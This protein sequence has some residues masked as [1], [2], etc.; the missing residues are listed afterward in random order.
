VS[1]NGTAVV[2]IPALAAGLY[3]VRADVIGWKE[4]RRGRLVPDDTFR[5]FA[6][7]VWLS[8]H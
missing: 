5:A 1:G 6:T 8:V 7:P 4:D 2:A 3:Y